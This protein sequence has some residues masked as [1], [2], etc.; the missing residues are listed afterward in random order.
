MR[1]RIGHRA[2]IQPI[3][4]IRTVGGTPPSTKEIIMSL[5]S[6]R[7]NDSHLSEHEAERRSTTIVLLDPT[8]PDGHS[9]LSQLSDHDVNVLLVVLLTGRASNAL[10]DFAHHED[11]SVT[12]AGWIYLDQVAVGL[13]SAGRT[14]G[15]IAATGPD[16][17][18]TLADIAIE[19]E[20]D[21]V[22]LPS[23]ILRLAR[24]VP[25]RL[26]ELAPVTICIPEF[27]PVA[28]FG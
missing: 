14:I 21:R 15:T 22:A 28:V 16:T 9:G 4:A 3:Q 25:A 8:S 27:H 18:R 20:A 19:N 24:D 11:V 26:T 2:F 5:P 7:P 1:T 23:S 13:E 17:A 6:D 12:E 10:R